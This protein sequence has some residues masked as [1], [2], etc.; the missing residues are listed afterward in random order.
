MP[1]GPAARP[2]T[3]IAPMLAMK[4]D[5]PDPPTGWAYEIKWDGN[6]CLAF[7]A[8][9][10][11]RLATRTGGDVTNRYPEVAPLGAALAGRSVVLDGEVVALD[12]HGAPSF[13]LLQR[14]MHRAAG[15]ASDTRGAPVHLVLFDVLWLDGASTMEL[16]WHERR[17][18]LE[19]LQLT[20]PAWRTP[21]AARDD[22]TALL[23]LARERGLEGLVAKRV[24][25]VYEPG[26][27]SPDWVKL[28]LDQRDDFVVGGWMEGKSGR[29]GRIG[30]LLVGQWHGDDLAYAGRV[31][32]GFDG[33]DLDYLAGLLTPLRRD[34]PPFT[35]G[36]PLPRDAVWADPEVVVV[37]RFRT[38]TDAG[39][40]RQSAFLGVRDDLGDI[41]TRRRPRR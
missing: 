21:P 34:D 41:R 9:D 4:A 8:D 3:F 31:G 6:R 38:W 1:R 16:P 33:A 11:V 10:A 30:S 7:V 14:R 29:A 13:Q 19:G 5:P 23:A 20:G 17:A 25:S 2:P 28:P 18:L 37:V 35:T 24:D 26:R 22:P 36:G 12:E 15:A 39:I 27:R 32:T 40:I